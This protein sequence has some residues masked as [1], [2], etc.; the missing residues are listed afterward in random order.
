MIILNCVCLL[1]QDLLQS[2]S[3][4]WGGNNGGHV[5]RGTIAL[6]CVFISAGPNGV[7]NLLHQI[8]R[9]KLKRPPWTPAD[10]R[11]ETAIRTRRGGRSARIR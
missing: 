3:R 4:V 5:L 10:V 11:G 7:V 2:C 1:L 9:Q 8:V 6:V